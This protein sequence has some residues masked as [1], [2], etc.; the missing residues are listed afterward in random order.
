MDWLKENWLYLVV[1]VGGALTWEI[2]KLLSRKLK[3]RVFMPLFEKCK[4][5][6]TIYTL[7]VVLLVIILGLIVWN[8]I[9]YFG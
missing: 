2:L 1:G 4:G 7:V 3:K 8:L 5:L 9:L 6:G